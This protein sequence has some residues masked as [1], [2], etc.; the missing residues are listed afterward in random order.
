M[1]L[2]ARH[3]IPLRHQQRGRDDGGLDEEAL[4][5][6]RESVAEEPVETECGGERG[7]ATA[8][9]PAPGLDQHRHGGE[10][11]ATFWGMVKR[12]PRKG[13]PITT[14]RSGLMEW[15]RLRNFPACTRLDGP[16]VKSPVEHDEGRREREDGKVLGFFTARQTSATAEIPDHGGRDG[17]R[18]DAAVDSNLDGR[19][20]ADLAEST[21][22]P[23]DEMCAD[24]QQHADLGAAKARAAGFGRHCRGDG[25]PAV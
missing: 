21:A 15:P 9:G 20:V 22:M 24:G 18:P 5:G 6:A 4:G 8:C 23:P 16:D 7:R 14:F 1:R 25:H 12:S 13:S 10:A 3:E 2:A 11:K 19:D 17:Q